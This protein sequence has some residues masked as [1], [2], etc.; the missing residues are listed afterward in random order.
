MTHKEFTGVTFNNLDPSGTRISRSSQFCRETTDK[1]I[2]YARNT[3]RRKALV[4]NIRPLCITDI[5]YLEECSVSECFVL[6]I[7]Q[8]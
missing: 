5:R 6:F 8:W 4:I 2:V 3:E 7:V 1:I